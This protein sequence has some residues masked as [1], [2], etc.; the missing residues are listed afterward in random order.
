MVIVNK[1]ISNH[2]INTLK[3]L[4][5]TYITHNQE[6][7]KFYIFRTAHAHSFIPIFLGGDRVKKKTRKGNSIKGIKD[8][9]KK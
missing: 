3:Y 2:R 9:P 5:S 7:Y 8:K 4:Q 6:V 1:L